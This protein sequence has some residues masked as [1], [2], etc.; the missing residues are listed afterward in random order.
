MIDNSIY[1]WAVDETKNSKWSKNR[2][3][4][5]KKYATRNEFLRSQVP[6][7]FAVQAF[8]RMLCM[9]GSKIEDSEERMLVVENIYE[10]HGQGDSRKYHTQSYKTYLKA[11]GLNDSIYSSPW[12]SSWIKNVLSL[13]CNAM[14]YA[15]YLAGIEYVYALICGDVSE[16]IQTFTLECEQTHYSKHAKLDWEHGKE[17]LMVAVSLG[18]EDEIIK[19]YFKKAQ[20][21]FLHMYGSLF[22]PTIAEM[23]EFNSE[24]I[25]FYYSRE[26]SQIEKNLL[27]MESSKNPNPRVLTICSGGEHLFEM[28]SNDTP[29]HFDMI[30]INIHQ[31]NLTQEKLKYILNH[32]DS[33]IV[34]EQG[35]GKFEKMFE[36]LR[37]YFN[38]DEKEALVQGCNETQKKLHFIVNILF[39]NDYLNTVFG[40]DATKYTVKSF[41]EHF[42]SVFVEKLKEQ[43]INTQNIFWGT[44]V[45]NFNEIKERVKHHHHINWILDNPKNINV[46]YYYDIIDIS[47]IGDWMSQDDFISVI[48]HMQKLMKPRAKLIS[49][50]LLGDYDLEKVLSKFFKETHVENDDTG[51]YS[52]VVVA[53]N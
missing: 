38:E 37:S 6:F 48:S 39:S 9:L 45:R 33:S 50:K 46:D 4:Q 19:E 21:D 28:L 32:D 23:K 3:Q 17:L 25:S 12:V 40:E 30:D 16:Y 43:E 24:N 51:F 20:T 18:N 14:E 31:I 34:S 2:F 42:Y 35:V 26:N 27:E 8:P 1:E 47:N 11:L 10:E 53:T 7:F 29:T 49:R 5:F 13:E 44:H 41:S 36:L 52:E 22:I 15:A